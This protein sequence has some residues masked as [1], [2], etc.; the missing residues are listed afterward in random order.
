[1]AKT[2]TIGRSAYFMET[3]F[4]STATR[5]AGFRVTRLMKFQATNTDYKE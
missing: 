3:P 1:M 2:K 4:S 5:P